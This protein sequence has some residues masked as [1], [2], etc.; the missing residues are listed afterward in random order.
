MEVF[1]K[2]KIIKNGDFL[3]VSETQ[4]KP[5]VKLNMNSKDLYTLILYDPNAIGGTH[6]HWTIVNIKNN[7]MKTGNVI[8]P[9]KGPSPPAKTGKHHYIFNLY[10]QTRVNK[11]DPI[12][13]RVFEINDFTRK[14]GLNEYISKVYFI[15]ENESGGR[16][17]KRTK[18]IINKNKKSRKN[19]YN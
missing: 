9:Y 7:D 18:R 8:I 6:I 19:R 3:K 11:K 12:N 10:K 4:I 17:R 1:Y 2:E 15:S 5:E 14:L 16:K 13:E